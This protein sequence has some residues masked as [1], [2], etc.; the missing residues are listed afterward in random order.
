MKLL[1]SKYVRLAAALLIAIVL[2]ASFGSTASAQTYYIVRPGDNAFRIA[3]VHGI[4]TSCLAN[5]NGIPYPYNVYAGQMLYIPGPYGCYSPSYYAGYYPP[6]YYPP[7]YYPR[8]VYGCFYRVVYGDTLS[9]I[10]RRYGT[11]YWALASANR[12]YN[13]NYIYAGQVLRI[14]GCR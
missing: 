4:S 8:P 6:A 2:I 5:A 1:S 10:A 11:S 14:P 7:A 12:L 3:L 9:S 13:P